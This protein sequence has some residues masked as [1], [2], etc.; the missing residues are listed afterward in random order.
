MAGTAALSQSTY[1][2]VGGTIEDTSKGLLPGVTVTA[3]NNAT[4]VVTTVVSNESGAYNLSSLLPGVYE[5]SAV[6]PGFRTR[7]YTDVRLG[8]ADRIRLNFVLNV[9]A[10]DTAVE[11]TVAAD[12]LLATASSSVGE[13]LSEQK[14]QQMRS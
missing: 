2:T 4:G 12:T 6:L 9:G 1:A 11:V 10:V 3:T 5:V 14:V 7:T 13:V 8:N